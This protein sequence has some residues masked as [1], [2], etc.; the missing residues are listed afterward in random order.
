MSPKPL[1][2]TLAALA[3]AVSPAGADGPDR[4]PAGVP[5][6]VA[7]SWKP[8]LVETQDSFNG[9][10]PLRGLAG[11]IVLFSE[12]NPP[13]TITCEGDLVVD[14]Y[15]DRPLATG[16]QAVRLERWV[17]PDPILKQL[18]HKDATDWGYSVF[19]PW[20]RTYRPDVSPIHLLVAFTPRGGGTL[21]ANSPSITLPQLNHSSACPSTLPFWGT[22]LESTELTPQP[23]TARVPSEGSEPLPPYTVEPPDVL[24]IDSAEGLLT[25]PVR[26]PHLVRPDGTVG[27][28]PYGSVSVAG[29]TLARAQAEVAG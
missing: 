16:G 14:L 25:P 9:G 13:R 27:L 28:G 22:I 18:L 6:K 5:C 12:L 21:Y 26:G 11:R 23:A 17:F 29:L 3:L 15:D 10:A 1:A 7:A 20:V 8:E 4:P 19:L 2:A 24:Q